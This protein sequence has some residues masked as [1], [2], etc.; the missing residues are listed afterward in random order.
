MHDRLLRHSCHFAHAELNMIPNN[1]PSHRP[2][3]NRSSATKAD[4]SNPSGYFIIL[5]LLAAHISLKVGGDHNVV[6]RRVQ[7]DEDSLSN[8]RENGDSCF[9]I[10]DNIF[11]S[12]IIFLPA[13]QMH[14]RQDR[15]PSDRIKGS[16]QLSDD[17][18]QPASQAEGPGTF[19]FFRLF[20]SLSDKIK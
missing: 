3:D 18:Q 20:L 4:S 2:Q 12:L 13:Q 10:T 9:G 19:R 6:S 8:Q 7:S 14:K 17:L 11:L 16:H 1:Y 15:R 5:Q